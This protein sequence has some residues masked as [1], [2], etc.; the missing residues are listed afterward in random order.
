M[1]HLRR[2]S[3]ALA[4]ALGLFVLSG[5]FG[6]SG[7]AAQGPHQAEKSNMELVGYHDLQGRSAYQPVVHKQGDRWVAYIGHHGDEVANPLTSQR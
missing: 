1:R 6:H 3:A 7:A 5:D 2:D 4:V